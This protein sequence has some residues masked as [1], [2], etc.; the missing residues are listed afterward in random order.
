MTKKFFL[1]G[2][3]QM[4]AGPSNVNRSLV[5]HCD[6]CMAYIHSSNRILRRLERFRMLFYPIVVVSGS[7]SPLEFSLLKLFGK[8]VIYLMHGSRWYEAKI[9]RLKTTE[10][11]LKIESDI[12]QYSRRI[13]CVSEK[14][15]LWVKQ[16]YPQYSD[17]ITYVNNGVSLHRRENVEKESFSIAVSGGNRFIKNNSTV[18]KAVEKLIAKGYECHVYVFGRFYEDNEDITHY[19]FVKVMGHLDKEDYYN[20]LDK[21]SLFVVDSVAE[22]FGLVSA[23]A[24][25]CNCSLLMSNVVGAGSIMELSEDDMVSDCY[26]VDEVAEKML[27]LLLNGNSRRIYDTIDTKASSEEQAYLNLKRIVYEM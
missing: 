16:E 18:C 22:P 8:K 20:A 15:S 13:V 9:N 23:D 14:Y 17:K 26:N 27:Q 6:S 12:L 21:I 2:S 10:R 24:L 11:S 1:L 3:W 4:N 25:N 19:P 7:L 5:R